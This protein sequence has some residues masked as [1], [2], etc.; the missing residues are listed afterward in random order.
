MRTRKYFDAKWIIIIIILLVVC[1]WFMWLC[2]D[3]SSMLQSKQSHKF[4]NWKKKKSIALIHLLN[5]N[6]MWNCK[7]SCWLLSC[8]FFFLNTFYWFLAKNMTHEKTFMVAHCTL[9][10][11]A[12]FH[13]A[14]RTHWAPDEKKSRK[15]GKF[16]N[17]FLLNYKCFIPNQ[18]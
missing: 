10:I 3:C 6:E 14:I 13:S 18:I 8:V 9:N 16:G 2:A 5:R 1:I 7:S 4:N 12:L 11:I 17:L 15:A